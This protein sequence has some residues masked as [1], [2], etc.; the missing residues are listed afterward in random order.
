MP[1]AV[2]K[3]GGGAFWI[4]LKRT[5]HPKNSRSLGHHFVDDFG[6]CFGVG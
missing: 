4:D 1:T 2:G 6:S 3:G 5:K